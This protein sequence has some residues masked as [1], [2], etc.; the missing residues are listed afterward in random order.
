MARRNRN[1]GHDALKRLADLARILFA[2]R[3]GKDAAAR[4]ASRP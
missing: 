4:G 1:F 3:V 2:G